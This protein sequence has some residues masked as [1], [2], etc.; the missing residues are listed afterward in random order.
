MTK[1]RSHGEGSISYSNS[2]D[3][4]MAQI[5]LPNG[6]RQTKYAK[7]QKEAKDWLLAQ[8][9]ALAEGLMVAKDIRLDQFLDIYLKDVASHNLRE[10]TLQAYESLVRIH[11]KPE[12]GFYKLSQLT[13]AVIQRFY[14]KKLE[15]LSKRT[16]QFIHS[17]LHKSFDQALRWNLVPRNVF[18]LV[19][20]PHP[21]RKTMTVWSREQ[22]RRFL[23]FVEEDRLYPLYTLAIAT[24]M[25]E[26]EILGLYWEDVDFI[27]SEI[28]VQRAIQ[29]LV[30]KG[31]TITEPKTKSSRRSITVAR[32]AMDTLRNHFDKAEIKTGLVFRTS[33]NTPFSPRNIVRHFKLMTKKAGLPEIRFHDLRHTAATL[34][35]SGGI[36]PKV[37]QEMLGHS[38]ISLTLDTYSHVVPTMQKEAADKMD[39]LLKL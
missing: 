29:Y 34:M 25:R 21:N 15:S 18:D 26:G 13:P 24:G 8:R 9:N 12:L 7:T 32:F 35:L 6:K 2:H 17:V 31:L 10:K 27:K 22:A 11:I 1:K 33:Q 28:N 20:A 16:V 5:T 19:D 39:V 14:S 37:V 36:H 30:G 38:Q 23:K 3:L 4:W